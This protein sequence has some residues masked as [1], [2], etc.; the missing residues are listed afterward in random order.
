MRLIRVALGTAFVF[1]LLIVGIVGP[2][3]AA[4]EAN[5]CVAGKLACASKKAS[6]LLKCYGK[7][8]KAGALV[9]AECLAKAQAKFDKCFA[10]IESK[11]DPEKPAT[12][13]RTTADDAALSAA[14]DELALDGACAADPAACPSEACAHSPC[15][16]GA[17]LSGCNDCVERICATAELDYC[18]TSSWDA[19]CVAAVE[20]LCGLSCSSYSGAASKCTAAKTN[21]AAKRLRSLLACF[22][23]AQKKGVELD[24]QC[25]AKAEAK[26]D[27]GDDPAA[28]CFAKVEA[29]QN[30][31][32]P[33]TDCPITGDSPAAAHYTDYA[34]ERL[35]CAL[36]DDNCSCCGGEC[37]QITDGLTLPVYDPA[38]GLVCGDASLAT[39][40]FTQ[41]CGSCDG[42]CGIG[43]TC[44][45][46]ECKY[47]VGERRCQ[48]VDWRPECVSLS[49]CN[50]IASLQTDPSGAWGPGVPLENYEYRFVDIVGYQDRPLYFHVDL[51]SFSTAHAY[52]AEIFS[53]GRGGNFYASRSNHHPDLLCD[54]ICWDGDGR[55]LSDLAV[56]DSKL[57]LNLT[58]RPDRFENGP[59][60]SLI[61]SQFAPRGHIVKF[62]P[63]A[64]WTGDTH[65][66]V[67]IHLDALNQPT[68][69]IV[70][71]RI[72]IRPGAPPAG[73]EV[74]ST[75]VQR[76]ETGHYYGLIFTPKAWFD[77]AITAS[78]KSHN[79]LQGHIVNI[80]D[81]A[82]QAFVLQL[83]A[84]YDIASGIHIGLSDVLNEGVYRWI[85]NSQIA[86]YF[87]WSGGEPNDS[88]NEDFVMMSMG[89][90]TWNDIDGATLLPTVVEYE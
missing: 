42:D 30:P 39:T 2:V 28:G 70:S 21:C 20:P 36:E 22:N 62:V 80:D 24:L 33:E 78:A 11:Q 58:T 82:E 60:T 76:P 87:N 1:S 43:Q 6:A 85:N 17:A 10:K 35:A 81:A 37:F 5:H 65:L 63:D 55:I 88:G 74:P 13:C 19:R 12:L 9:D 56:L 32:K 68:V 54:P 14:I 77:A 61:G 3:A 4:P 41:F 52:I 40:N 79:G 59:A 45:N 84:S 53:F 73:Q 38:T 16:S 49:L 89:S 90:G 67:V 29:K 26:F 86:S 34:A 75:I 25:I 83:A 48:P 18:C 15:V 31:D 69:P 71:Y 46:G 44:V 7:A 50:Y 72:R 8:Q 27:G 23:K 51:A 64:G 57:T 66:N 47:R